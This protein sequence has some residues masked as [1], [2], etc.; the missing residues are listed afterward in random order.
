MVGR[1][2]A[3]LINDRNESKHEGG[4]QERKCDPGSGDHASGERSRGDTAG[5]A[6]AGRYFAAPC[7]RLGHHGEIP[8]GN[9]AG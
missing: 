6:P 3:S 2:H 5:S 4:L 9:T 1:D 7:K 8:G